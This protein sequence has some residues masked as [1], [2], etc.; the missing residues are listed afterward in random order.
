MVMLSDNDLKPVT[1][2]MCVWLSGWTAGV[3]A[4]SAMVI[5][6]WKA[7]LKSKQPK[8]ILSAG[9]ALF[10]TLFAV[11]FLVGEVLGIGVL[12]NS[13]SS[14]TVI[15]MAVA[16]ASN[17]L[18]HELLKAPTRLGR[19]ALDEIQ[20]F[21]LFLSATEEDEIEA[22]SPPS[23][24]TWTPLTS[25][26]LTRLLSTLKMSGRRSSIISWPQ[27]SPTARARRQQATSLR[28]QW[29]PQSARQHLLLQS[30]MH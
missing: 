2:F 22:G 14:T 23:T 15:V 30:E 8:M 18:Y 6:L 27:P 3:I 20:G 21:K 26:C 1:L 25:I 5:N 24:G 9:G 16:V 13:T 10:A 19:V 12:A 7:V 28:A 11:P 29:P 4:L 17:F